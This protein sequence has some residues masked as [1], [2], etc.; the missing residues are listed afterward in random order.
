[1]QDQLRISYITRHSPLPLNAGGRFRDN[2][3]W[4]ALQQFAD[5][6]LTVLGDDPGVQTRLL[7]KRQGVIF[8][9]G[10]RERH[11]SD[12]LRRYIGAIMSGQDPS[13][14]RFLSR[15]RMA[16][17]GALIQKQQPDLIIFGHTILAPAMAAVESLNVP[18]ILDT[19]NVESLL[20]W[21]IANQAASP[22]RRW[23]GRGHAEYLRRF[24]QQWLPRF[25]GVWAVSQDD[26]DW[27]QQHFPQVPRARVPNV[28]DVDRYQWQAKPEA[29]VIAF[30][31]WYRHWPNR[32]AASR[33]I[34]ISKQLAARS[35]NHRLLI[36]GRDLPEDLRTAAAQVDTIEVVGEVADVAPYLARASIIAAPLYAGS[37]SNLK[38]IEAMAAG[39]PAITTPSGIAGLAEQDE[40]PL[41]IANNDAETLDR[42]IWC[43][44]HP[45]ESAQAGVHGRRWVEQNMSQTALNA[46]VKAAI[47]QMASTPM[48]S[49]EH[50]QE[51]TGLPS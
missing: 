20:S 23:A 42:L 13:A 48:E 25:S 9:P 21:R 41:Y 4:T 12:R 27:Y 33:L 45:S 26:L 18:I 31:G 10:L 44:Q 43:L 14:A 19:H 35:V 39:R 17:L 32:D 11:S 15:R 24:E 29:G 30:A 40:L 8:L 22:I 47:S 2:A 28:V 46:I 49:P 5:V 38:I 1:M 3:I 34:A 7:L 50:H 16:V 6:S 36:I 51:T 37:G